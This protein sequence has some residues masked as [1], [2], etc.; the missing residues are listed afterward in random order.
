MTTSKLSRR[1]SIKNAAAL[2][3]AGA[4]AALGVTALATPA[5]AD[6]PNMEAALASLQAALASLRDAPDDKG[7]YKGRAQQLVRQAIADVEAGIQWAKT[8]R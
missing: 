5:E 4:V 2:G 3:I 1:D 8:H 7:G 6:Q